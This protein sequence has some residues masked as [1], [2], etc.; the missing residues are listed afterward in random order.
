MPTVACPECS[1]LNRVPQE[2]LG[3]KP[4]CGRCGAALFQGRPVTLTAANFDHHAKAELPLLVD[5]W[6]QWCAPCNMMAPQFA[7]AAQALEP[8][9][10]LGKLDT[11]AEP[12]IAARFSIRSI[13]TMI[14]LG[15]GKA[16]AR[17]SGAMPAAQIVQWARS[18]V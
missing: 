11:E 4:K 12:Q 3:D 16:I 7:A 1:S 5:F 10:R 18:H 9:V 8:H 17:V 14:L 6:A 2:R 13:P 15:N